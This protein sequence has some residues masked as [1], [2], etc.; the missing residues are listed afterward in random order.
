MINF[1]NLSS[2]SLYV[3][4]TAICL[5]T[6]QAIAGATSFVSNGN[7]ELAKIDPLTGTYT[8][9]TT[10]VALFDIA[11]SVDNLLI[12]IDGNRT[13]YRIDQNSGGFSPIA[14]LN[15]AINSLGFG[16]D[17]QLY[18]TAGEA[19]YLIDPST[20]VVNS[21]STIPGFFSSGDIAYDGSSDRFF[22]TSIFGNTNKLYAIALDG[23][24]QEIGDIGFADVFG[25]LFDNGTLYGY[26]GNQQ[27]TINTTTG[28]GS[29]NRTINTTNTTG[30]IFGA[31]SLPKISLPITTPPVI[32]PPVIS[33][34]IIPNPI[35]PDPI[36]SIPI[37]PNPI[38][39]QP[40]PIP[41]SSKVP[42]PAS[43]LAVLFA[44]AGFLAFSNDKRTAKKSAR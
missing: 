28:L 8:P 31:A 23:T 18:G 33:N 9:V 4:G 12:G 10:G 24:S 17:N 39:S 27:I 42:E 40:L 19:F 43:G 35:I 1:K 38:I 21:I 34:P 37:V 11:F 2:F 32:S 16:G 44:M 22:A 15:V 29:F 3:L 30:Q 13:L 7:G 14:N 41:P 20:G 26:T 5:L 25:L 36:V 6:T